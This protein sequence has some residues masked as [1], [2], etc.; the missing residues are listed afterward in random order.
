MP[1]AKS[2]RSPPT[3]VDGPVQAEEAGDLYRRH[4]AWLHARLRRRLGPGL[5]AEAEDLVQETYVRAVEL[6]RAAPIRHPRALLLKI[7]GRLAMDYGRRAHR[8]APLL[9]DT[10]EQIAAAPEQDA[11]LQL[12]QIILALPPRL[13]DVFVLSRVAGLSYDQI[14]GELGVSVKTVEARMS[15]ALAICAAQMNA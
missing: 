8:L 4:A 10:A 6:A 2:P 9:D 13:R 15:K 12:K 3:Q 5:A 1:G 14:A 11:D 7:A